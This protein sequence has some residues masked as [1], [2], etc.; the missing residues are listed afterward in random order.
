MLAPLVDD[1]GLLHRLTGIDVDDWLG[2]A[3][4]GAYSVR[5]S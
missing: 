4:A 5:R 3:G 2:Q 1:I